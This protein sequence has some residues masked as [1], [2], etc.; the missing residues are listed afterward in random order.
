ML[1]IHCNN[2]CV[3]VRIAMQ[4]IEI[5]ISFGKRLNRSTAKCLWTIRY[6]RI[7]KELSFNNYHSCKTFSWEKNLSVRIY[8][9]NLISHVLVNSRPLVVLSRREIPTIF[10]I[11][12]HRDRKMAASIIFLFVFT[13]PL[14][15]KFCPVQPT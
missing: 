4:H 7:C 12:H 6:H 2:Q 10:V 11:F 1:L 15:S 13:C 9:C 14:V 5:L 3:A 8:A